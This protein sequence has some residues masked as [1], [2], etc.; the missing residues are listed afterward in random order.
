MNPNFT[1]SSATSS[2]DQ[3]N[4]DDNSDYF[5]CSSTSRSGGYNSTTMNLIRDYMTNPTSI[6]NVLLRKQWNDAIELIPIQL[7]IAHCEAV[8]KCPHLLEYEVNPIYWIVYE[9]NNFW[10]AACSYVKYW[11]YRKVLFGPVKAF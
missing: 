2:T 3:S 8:I 11:E 10:T 1:S 5:A 9:R 7:R 6:T 4:H